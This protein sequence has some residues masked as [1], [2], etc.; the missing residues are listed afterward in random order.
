MGAASPALLICLFVL[1][2]YGDKAVFARVASGF[3]PTDATGWQSLEWISLLVVLASVGGIL[4]WWWQG[5]RSAPALPVCATVITTVVSALLVVALIYRVLIEPPSVL[6]AGAAGVDTIETKIGAYLGLALSVALLAGG[7]LSL[8]EDG[9]AAG[10]APQE[11]E[12]LRLAPR[13]VAG[14]R[15]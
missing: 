15:T 10:D 1:P 5:T 3:G 13:R 8:R 9:I 6:L 4:A 7:Y 2:W 12:T 14:A 11:I